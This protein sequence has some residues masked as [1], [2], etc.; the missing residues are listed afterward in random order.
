MQQT[1]PENDI[2]KHPETEKPHGLT[3]EQQIDDA[4]ERILTTQ[5]GYGIGEDDEFYVTRKE[6]VAAA[7]KVTGFLDIL[8][9][10]P[11]KTIDLSVQGASDLFLEWSS[12]F[13]LHDSSDSPPEWHEDYYEG[14]CAS[15]FWLTKDR[16]AFGIRTSSPYSYL[17]KELAPQYLAPLLKGLGGVIKKK[18]LD[19][20][21]LL[22]VMSRDE[23]IPQLE[24]DF[25]ALISLKNSIRSEVTKKWGEN[26]E[27][28][29]ARHTPA[30]KEYARRTGQLEDDPPTREITVPD[31]D[32]EKN[33]FRDKIMEVHE[34][35]VSMIHYT[36]DRAEKVLSRIVAKVSLEIANGDSIDQA[37][38]GL[39]YETLLAEDTEENEVAPNLEQ[40]F[41]FY[42]ACLPDTARAEA[43]QNIAVACRLRPKK[44][45]DP[46]DTPP[47]ARLQTK[48]A[49]DWL[50]VSDRTPFDRPTNATSIHTQG[51]PG[52]ISTAT[53]FTH[54]PSELLTGRM[55]VLPE[56][57][58]RAY[59]NNTY[60]KDSDVPTTEMTYGA[61][62]HDTPSVVPGYTMTN[63]SVNRYVAPTETDPY[64]ASEIEI[65]P[66]RLENLR[67]AAQEAGL[68]A[69]DELLEHIER[70]GQLRVDRVVEALN[71]STK[72]ELMLGGHT[73][74]LLDLN[75][76]KG[77]RLVQDG[78]LVGNCTISAVVLRDVLQLLGM[79]EISVLSGI[80][81]D[82]T[83][84]ATLPGHSQ[85]GFVDPKSGERRIVDATSTTEEEVIAR[86]RR[87][88][89][90]D[91][92]HT[93]KL[94]EV[95]SQERSEVNVG[96]IDKVQLAEVF[97]RA[98]Q[99]IMLYA[100]TKAEAQSSTPP[101]NDKRRIEVLAALGQQHIVRELYQLVQTQDVQQLNDT[102]PRLKAYVDRLT[103]FEQ[104]IQSF[105]RGTTPTAEQKAAQKALFGDPKD[106]HFLLST[107]KQL[108]DRLVRL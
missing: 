17:T 48:K 66:E 13:F 50:S 35:Y 84:I 67:A 46:Y 6:L 69:F 99:N 79:K 54:E 11:E 12:P 18:I 65:S 52:A 9:N 77:S 34:R 29:L 32:S 40:L 33:R 47:S 86:Q 30:A 94:H 1:Y 24:T 55:L 93:K 56:G 107:A 7:P 95:S 8:V 51:D 91:L 108:Y 37:I 25:A 105:S 42:L 63:L 85:V 36:D 44:Y 96:E 31:Q 49:L 15:A 14:G 62:P 39:L 104:T 16:A 64:D 100:D 38:K 88:L 74:M 76:L 83:G 61:L 98:Y 78:Y 41:D 102:I 73:N 92:A 101:Q 70:S 45:I 20:E 97:S 2:T 90:R 89:I 3:T 19:L 75:Q 87:N 59:T 60:D 103:Q 26:P 81:L 106:L 10:L 4:I 72:Y 57:Q 27:A 53:V 43:I 71:Y 22:G 58:A 21:P 23:M 82:G 80:L 5:A 28:S 68:T